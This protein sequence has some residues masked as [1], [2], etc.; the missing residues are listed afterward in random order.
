[1]ACF[2]RD[3][4]WFVFSVMLSMCSKV[5]SG[6]QPIRMHYLSLRFIEIHVTLLFSCQHGIRAITLHLIAI[7]ISRKPP[8]SSLVFP[9][10]LASVIVATYLHHGYQCALLSL[11]PP[12][13]LHH[14][15]RGLMYFLALPSMSSTSLATADLLPYLESPLQCHLVLEHQ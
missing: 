13:H 8:S 1:M 11:Q 5:L 9:S 3:V 2:S 7:I 14:H 4:Y 15:W 6:S 12:M 10:P